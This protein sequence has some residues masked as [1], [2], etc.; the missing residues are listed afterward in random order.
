MEEDKLL[1]EYEYIDRDLS[2]LNFNYRVLQEAK[3][4]SVRLMERLKFFAI[5][6]SNLGEFFR[7]R[8]A[9]HKNIEK[10]GKK[11]KS[12]LDYDPKKLLKNLYSIVNKQLSEFNDLFDNDLI[13]RLSRENIFLH[14][15]RELSKQQ[16][17]FLDI[18]FR[19]NL[20][21]FVQPVLLIGNRIKPFLNNSELYLTIVLKAKEGDDEAEQYAIV[22][23]PSDHLPRFIILPSLDESHHVILLDEIVRYSLKW[24]FPG[25][26]VIHSYSIKITRDAE[27]YIEDEFSG[28]LLDKIKKSLIKRHIGPASRL[29]Y[30]EA[31]PKEML[32]YFLRLLEIRKTDLT[33]EGRYHNNFDFFNFPDFKL[34]HLKNKV[35]KPLPYIPFLNSSILNAIEKEDHLLYFPFHDY[36]VMVKFFEEASVDPEVSS[37]K[38]T[39]YRVAKKSRIIDALIEAAAQ[40]KNVFA[41]L[42]VKARFDEEA[43]LRWGEEMEK[44]GIKVRYSFPGLKVHA[45]CA[46]ITKKKNNESIHCAY[47]STGNFHEQTARA[48]TDHGLFTTHDKITQEVARVFAFLESTKLPTQPFHHLLVGQFNM[49][50]ELKSLIRYEKEMAL[51]GKKA[52]IILKMNGLQDKDMIDL[53]YEAGQAGVKIE[54][55]IRGICCII[56]NKPKL[57]DNIRGISIVDRFLE[58]SRVYYF[59]HGGED[60]IYISSSDWMV[61]NLHFRIEVAFPIYASK[62]KKEVMDILQF[63]LNDN[64]KARSIDYLRMNEYL[65]NPDEK[66]LR[67]Q[68]ETYKY[69]KKLYKNSISETIIDTLHEED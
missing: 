59:H 51:S 32:H 30:D 49:N 18:F 24:L 43:N 27:L 25:Y 11:T 54:L 47:L 46:L 35:L 39:L 1:S 64:V 23:I 37:I 34:K 44:S 66:N 52:H 55:I 62:L 42:E 10:L 53:L 60:N 19:E 8:V 50:D 68:L 40:G 65:Q 45:K 48:Y 16:Q 22:K 67:S 57:S 31:M 9:H 28:D 13:P 41:F 26:H 38:L 36:E 20:L 17:H 63:Q 6:S 21:P 29:V 7:I 69:Y 58:H 3:D 12:E 33:P 5:Y 15:H 14:S 2:W 61:R 4:P 56:P